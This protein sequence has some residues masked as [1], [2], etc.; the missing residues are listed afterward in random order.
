MLAKGQTQIHPVA[1]PF[2]PNHLHK[3]PNGVRPTAGCAAANI[4]V[5]LLLLSCTYTPHFGAATVYNDRILGAIFA[6]TQSEWVNFY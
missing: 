4:N 2:S 5:P 6:A 3:R 1:A